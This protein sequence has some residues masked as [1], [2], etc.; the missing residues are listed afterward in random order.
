MGTHISHSVNVVILET[1]HK[2]WAR[3][4]EEEFG[5]RL[6]NVDAKMSA[7]AYKAVCEAFV[8]SQ[9]TTLNKLKAELEL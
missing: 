5:E 7:K 2:V 9:I 8:A 1:A 4:L 3:W 6:K